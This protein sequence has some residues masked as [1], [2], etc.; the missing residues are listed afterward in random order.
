M[1][2]YLLIAVLI[3]QS[4]VSL[5]QDP[6]LPEGLLDDPFATPETTIEQ[7]ETIDPTLSFGGFWESRIGGRLVDDNNQRSASLSEIRLQLEFSKDF[8]LASINLVGDFIYDHLAD[9]H[10]IDLEKGQG[11]FDLREA[12]FEASPTDNVD[13][14]FGRQILT[15]GTGDLVFINDLF[16]KDW[17]SFFL[18]RDE[19]YLKAPSDALKASLYSNVVN[20]DLIYNPHFD[21]D[22]L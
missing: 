10:S 17:H 5:A 12:N 15:W 22:R 14:K 3:V 9:Q 11:Y 13:L 16:S 20:V 21:A 7:D 6:L 19:E 18:G 4:H 1:Y 8:D 2:R